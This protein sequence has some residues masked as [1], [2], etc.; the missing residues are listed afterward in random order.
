M[1]TR[2]E[3]EIAMSRAVATARLTIRILL[4]AAISAVLVLGPLV[5]YEL[6][7]DN[8][9]LLAAILGWGLIYLPSSTICLALLGETFLYAV[10]GIKPH[11]AAVME[12]SYRERRERNHAPAKRTLT[13]QIA[14]L[15]PF[16]VSSILTWTL[17]TRSAAIQWIKDDPQTVR[18]I[19]MNLMDKS[20]NRR[21]NYIA[22]AV[23]QSVFSAADAFGRAA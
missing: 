21:V 9:I 18:R 17:V 19:R 23:T 8:T 12:L 4:S 14:L 10:L 13:S 7:Q 16:F 2:D 1:G 6:R 15:N 22:P 20:S 5:W 11:L 3:K